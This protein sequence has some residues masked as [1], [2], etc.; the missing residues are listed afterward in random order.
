ME[1]SIS[2]IPNHSVFLIPLDFENLNN[3]I[4]EFYY[5]WM[6]INKAFFSNR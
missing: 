3:Y 6:K 1:Y 4:T 2:L 5:A